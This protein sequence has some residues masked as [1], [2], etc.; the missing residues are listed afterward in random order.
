MG[1]QLERDIGSSVL[2][3]LVCVV[4]FLTGEIIACLYADGNDHVLVGMI[5]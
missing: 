5:K 2:L 3:L 1:Y 4:F